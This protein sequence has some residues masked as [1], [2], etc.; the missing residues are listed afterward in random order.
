MKNVLQ[1]I[2]GA[3]MALSGAA[4]PLWLLTLEKVGQ[5]FDLRV[6]VSGVSLYALVPL[7]SSAGLM[8]W[9]VWMAYTNGI[10]VL[11][12]RYKYRPME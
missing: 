6:I 10:A 3:L 8:I 4:I 11:G 9:G 2:L 12:Q 5:G 7:L 1:T